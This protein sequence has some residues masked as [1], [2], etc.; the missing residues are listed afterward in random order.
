MRTGSCMTNF[1]FSV[2]TPQEVTNMTT[3]AHIIKMI[4]FISNVLKVKNGIGGWAE[5]LNA[6]E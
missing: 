4:L 5:Q 6:D 3:T 2:F 1:S